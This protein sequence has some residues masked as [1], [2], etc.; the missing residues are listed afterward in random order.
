MSCYP[1]N[2]FRH[3]IQSNHFWPLEKNLT[4]NM[5]RTPLGSWLIMF[6]FAFTNMRWTQT[7]N[8]T[9]NRRIKSKTVR[10]E[11]FISTIQSLDQVGLNH[12]E[13]HEDGED[14]DEDEGEY[15]EPE[16]RVSCHL[17]KNYHKFLNQIE[18]N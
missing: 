2:L 4:R 1:K 17:E 13:K 6:T 5:I 15:E 3:M 16:L 11:K 10:N 18:F 7:T 8:I 14:E 12:F 9:I